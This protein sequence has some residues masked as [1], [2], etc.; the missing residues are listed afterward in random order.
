MSVPPA[1]LRSVTLWEGKAQL[2]VVLVGHGWG[3]VTAPEMDG[4]FDGLAFRILLVI[5]DTAAP[6]LAS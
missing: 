3:H 4:L 2:N 6:M 1:G 5:L